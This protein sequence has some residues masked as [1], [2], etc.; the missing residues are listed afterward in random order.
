M[1]SAE[2]RSIEAR[3]E[4]RPRR[5]LHLVIVG[6]HERAVR[7]LQESAGA[8]GWTIESHTGDTAGRG[9]DEIRAA[10][11]RSDIVVIHTRINSHG[12]MFAA[13]DWA[14]RLQ[15]P[16]IILRAG[17]GWKELATAVRRV[18]VG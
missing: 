17:G 11:G 1:Y 14:R 6:G 18:S 7:H 10:I 3:H 9:I 8:C 2:A 12:S 5:P 13:K 16:T 15:R 4:T